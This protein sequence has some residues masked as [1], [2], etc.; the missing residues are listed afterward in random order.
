MRRAIVLLAALAIT[1][2]LAWLLLGPSLRRETPAPAP[3]APVEAATPA[4]K[5]ASEPIESAP[6]AQREEIAAPA[7]PPQAAQDAHLIVLCRAKETGAPLANQDVHL[8]GGDVRNGAIPQASGAQGKLNEIVTTGADGRAEFVLAAGIAT[9]LSAYP[10]QRGGNAAARRELA[11]LAPGE[12]REIVLELLTTNDARFCLRVLSRETRQ[13]I[14]AA[15]V[16]GG[17]SALETDADGRIDVPC[18]TWS[19]LRLS[20]LARGYAECAISAQAGHET[21]EQA[22]VILL[23]RSCTL[24]GHL[25][26]GGNGH[27]VLQALTEGYRLQEQ[28]PSRLT[29]AILDVDDRSWR[30]EFDATG[31]AEIQGLPPNAPLRVSLFDGH[32][33]LVELPERVTIAPGATREVELRAASTCTLS[34]IV[35]DDAGQPVPDQTLWLLRCERGVRLILQSYE[36]DELVA[37]AKTG[38]DGRF[39]MPKV[40]AG[41]WRLG[42]EAK[43]RKPEAEVAADAVAPLAIVVE[44]AAGE[45]THEVELTVHRGLTISGTVLDP[46][47]KPATRFG[48]SGFAPSTYIGCNGRKD[49]SFV[50]GPLPPGSFLLTAG[51]H[52]GSFAD[53]ERVRADTGARDVVLHLRRGGKLAGRVVD[54]RTGEGAV[55]SIAVSIPA[56]PKAN[57]HMPTSKPDGSFALQGMLPGT[58]A[59]AATTTD[60]RVGILRGVELPEGGDV[61]DLVLQLTPGA[62]L[63]VRYDG[64]Q[65]VCSTQILVDG[66]VVSTDGVEKSTSKTFAAPP[67][68]VSVRCRLNPIGKTFVREIALAAGEERELVIKDED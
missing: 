57:I 32:K 67:G 28:D 2:A 33:P 12:T 1:A 52:T 48:V 6:A 27:Y 55:A 25:K 30:A 49:G 63:R 56:D 22:L 40:S 62:R 43:F 4:S 23:D 34:G 61:H 16:R 39:V 42:P 10:K 37:R 59:L 54:A 45:T 44:I 3:A 21:P 14:A 60:G 41:T 68:A 50:L 19:I 20:I 53:S 51:D 17:P 58:Y 47:G 8:A 64:A 11:A 15:E 13:P 46:D 29:G 65:D 31:R 24:V 35:R 26:D 18:A 7:Q 66:V 5:L 9:Q 36:E 38:A